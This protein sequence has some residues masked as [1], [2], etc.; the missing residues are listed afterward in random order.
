MGVGSYSEVNGKDLQAVLGTDYP[1]RTGQ[2]MEEADLERYRA[3]R[4]EVCDTL[5]VLKDYVHVPAQQKRIDSLCLLL[6]EKESLLSAVMNTFLQLQEA[7]DL[8][9]EKI[10]VIVSQ[11]KHA[12]KNSETTTEIASL[13][14]DKKKKGFWSI[15]HRKQ[16][17]FCNRLIDKT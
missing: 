1:D 12:T 5:Q 2:R 3:K 4:R 16:S 10:P 13:E 17:F 14:S 8:V 11:M 9:R 15:F 7:G 6:Q